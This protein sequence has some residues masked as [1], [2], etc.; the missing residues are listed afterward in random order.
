MDL[1]IHTACSIN[2]RWLWLG[3]DKMIWCQCLWHLCSRN[4]G[5]SSSLLQAAAAATLNFRDFH[6]CSVECVPGRAA[7]VTRAPTCNI[8]W[9]AL[10]RNQ[11]NGI[12][13]EGGASVCERVRTAPAHAGRLRFVG[14]HAKVSHLCKE[15]HNSVL[16]KKVLASFD[17]HE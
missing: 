11:E 8:H 15:L 13:W 1:E 17:N 14:D 9:Q 12:A 16:K 4:T 6:S 10:V 2:M 3:Q 7:N 5:T